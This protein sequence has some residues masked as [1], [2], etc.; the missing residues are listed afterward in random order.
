MEKEIDIKLAYD[1]LEEVSKIFSEYT[2]SI[3]DKDIQMKDCLSSQNYDK[4]IK[5]L[6]SKYALPKGRLYLAY[7]DDLVVGCIAL[8]CIDDKY[9]EMKRLFVRPGNR[10][11]SIGRKLVEKVIEDAVEIG[12]EYMRLDTFPFM[13]SATKMYKSY[14]FYEIDP[15]NDNPASRAI[16]MQKDLKT[17]RRL[18]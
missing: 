18:L 15:Y 13:E 16:F 12:Y 9:C 3:L 6:K 4:E 8:R 7:I 17:K 1:N 10:G 11:Y 14:G 5:D 2:N